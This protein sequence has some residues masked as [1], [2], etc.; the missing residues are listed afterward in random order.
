MAASGGLLMA[1]KSK[2]KTMPI[3]ERLNIEYWKQACSLQLLRERTRRLPALGG[4]TG[5]CDIA[6]LERLRDTSYGNLPGLDRVPTD[7]FI[8]SRGEPEQRLVT[9]IG[10]LPYR[11]AR[12]PWSTA[13]SGIPLTFVA[14]ICFA[15][16]RD[17]TPIIPGD[18]LL[19]FTEA[20]N[21]GT[22]EDPLHDFTGEA[23]DDSYLLFEWVSFHDFPLIT[24][25]E[26]PE[27]GL[28]IMPCYAAIYRTWDYPQADEFAYPDLAENIPGV[29]EATKI[30]G[31]CPWSEASWSDYTENETSEYLCSLRS[32]DHEMSWPFP[33]LNI[34][35]DKDWLDWGPGG[36]LKIGDVGFINLFLQ[37]DGTIRWR[38]HTP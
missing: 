36:P 6:A 5:P 4:I 31:I 37:R 22:E 12:K 10:G 30:G 1:S 29:I 28:E 18:V 33:F 20:K 11:E 15:D 8:W 23:E 19:I 14:Q 16:S 35:D 2:E 38:F 7:V 13:P 34:P 17:L 25:Q 24:Q 32:I 27:T 26:I 21:W 9:K 3:H